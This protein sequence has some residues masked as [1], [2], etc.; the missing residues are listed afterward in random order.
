MMEE[1]KQHFWHVILYYFKKGKNVTDIQ[2]K[3][4]AVHGEGAMTDPTCQ[5]W[6]AKFRAPGFSLDDAPQSGRP[7]EVDS[8]QT[9]T[10]IENDQ[11]YTT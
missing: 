1:N 11:S 7:A 8:D 5:K 9:D 3:I 4:R 10:F 6:H 2:K